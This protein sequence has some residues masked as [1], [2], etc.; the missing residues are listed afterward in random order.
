MLFA[1]Y[2]PI[3][4]MILDLAEVIGGLLYCEYSNS[5][6]QAIICKEFHVAADTFSY[7]I[8]I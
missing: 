6:Y 2:L 4:T 8:Y 7:V 3:S 5:I 1:I